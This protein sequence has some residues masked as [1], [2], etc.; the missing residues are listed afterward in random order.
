MF[1]RQR[2]GRRRHTLSSRRPSRRSASI[3]S[4]RRWCAQILSPCN[5]SLLLLN[6]SGGRA[7]VAELEFHGIPFT[8]PGCELKYDALLQCLVNVEMG[9]A[10]LSLEEQLQRGVASQEGWKNEGA[11]REAELAELE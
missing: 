3:S 6:P 5:H 2:S 4:T 10:A 7:Q 9:E 1:R 11:M 8:G